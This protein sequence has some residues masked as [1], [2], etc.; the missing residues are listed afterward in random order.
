MNDS[1]DE[2]YLFLRL[3]AIDLNTAL[4][5][6]KVLRRYEA[7]EVKYPLLRDITVTYARP[8]SMNKGDKITKHVLSAKKYVPKNMKSL[9]EE[10]LSVRM[11]QFAHTDLNYYGPTLA[12][13]TGKPR[14]TFPMALRGHDY[15]KLLRTLP[16]IEKLIKAVEYNIHAELRINEEAF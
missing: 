11:Q 16:E 9:H 14:S 13:F 1:T 3:Y 5:T 7:N 4:G 2:Q 12:K 8:F 10:L 6:I 15:A